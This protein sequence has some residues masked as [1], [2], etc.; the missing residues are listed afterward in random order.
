MS[1]EKLIAI[2]HK[3]AFMPSKLELYVS[4][5]KIQ[6]CEYCKHLKQ[7]V[8]FQGYD[9]T[10]IMYRCKFLLKDG[11]CNHYEAMGFRDW[12]PLLNITI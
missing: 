7:Y 9:T 6:K 10:I 4:D 5:D 11:S 2:Q 12:F 3:E 8:S 1:N